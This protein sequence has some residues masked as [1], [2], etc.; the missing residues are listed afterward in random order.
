M[1]TQKELAHVVGH[2]NFLSNYAIILILFCQTL[3]M[4]LGII[5]GNNTVCLFSL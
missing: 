4:S 2:L 5:R 1:G 3:M